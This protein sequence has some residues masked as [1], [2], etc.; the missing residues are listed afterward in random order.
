MRKHELQ[1]ANFVCTFGPDHDLIDKIDDIV[2]PSFFGDT[3]TRSYGDTTFYIYE[4]KWIELGT[5][6]NAEL[7]IMG[8]FIKDTML[9]REQILKNGKLL[10]SHNEMQSTPSAFFVLML[11]DHRLLYFAETLF[12]PELNAFASTMQIFLRRIWRDYLNKKHKEEGNDKTHKDLRALH[13][14]PVLNI[15]P[16]AKND[17]IDSLM[18]EF[19]RI[20]K[21][22]FRLIRPN[23]ETDASEVFQ[24]VRNRFQPLSPSRL[25]IEMAD[26]DGLNKSES[27]AAVKEATSGMNTDI[28]V[29][30]VDDQGNRIKADNNE[31]ALRIPVENP[32]EAEKPLAKN[33]Y[34]E[35]IKQVT[36]GAVKRF[37]PP[38]QV[39]DKLKELRALVL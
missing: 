1:I 25:D 11:K 27:I 7:A 24:S 19:E 22:R 15:V 29:S 21:I 23:Q 6:V 28:I 31:F 38:Q 13:P 26:S 33:L 36:G 9:K 30:G 8:R 37:I 4:P 5:G 3:L 20:E 35:F 34:S 32:P 2:I 17:R 18:K 16:V 12:A 10:E 14:M 39:I